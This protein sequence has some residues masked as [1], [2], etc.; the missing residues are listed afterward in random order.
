MINTIRAAIVLLVFF[1]V[2]LFADGGSSGGSSSSTASYAQSLPESIPKLVDDARYD[3]AIDALNTFISEES[4]N[5]DAWNLLGY[6]LRKVEL[7]DDSLKA[8]KKALKLDRKHLGAREYL[9]ELYLVMG[10]PRKA[11][12]QLKKLKSYCGDCEQFTK[13]EQAISNYQESS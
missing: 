4:R 13:L 2:N 7:Y 9:G 3:E 11:K 8:Y 12:K 10:E 5:A 1:S 6:S